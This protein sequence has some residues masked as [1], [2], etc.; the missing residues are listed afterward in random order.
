M[1]KETA[2]SLVALTSLF[3]GPAFLFLG[4]RAYIISYDSAN[5]PQT[6]GRVTHRNVQNSGDTDE[7][8]LY[9]SIRYKYSVDLEEYESNVI[10]FQT[11]TGKSHLYPINR[12]YP[13]EFPV[14]KKVTVYYNPRKPEVAVLFPGVTSGIWCLLICG[15]FFTTTYMILALRDIR[16]KRRKSY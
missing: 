4:L 6:I 12:V 5:W 11:N 8:G 16:R 14:G 9:L 1:D 3:F 15:V 10:Y 13:S 7:H 2:L